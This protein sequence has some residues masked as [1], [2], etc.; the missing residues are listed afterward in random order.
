MFYQ[1]IIE[2]LF[3]GATEIDESSWGEKKISF[4]I[5]KAEKVAGLT[6]Y[7]SNPNFRKKMDKHFGKN[8]ELSFDGD[9]GDRTQKIT[10]IIQ[11]VTLSNLELKPRP[12]P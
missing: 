12:K 6:G 10:E 11:K 5:R 4:I 1:L 8:W 7:T 2:G 9:V 3:P